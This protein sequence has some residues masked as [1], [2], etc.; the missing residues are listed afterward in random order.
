MKKNEIGQIEI[1]DTCLTLIPSGKASID[2]CLQTYPEHADFLEPLLQT[3]LQAHSH[4]SPDGPDDAYVTSTKIRIMNQ[5]QALNQGRQNV[6]DKSYRR[7]IAFPRPSLAFLSLTLVLIM[8]LSGIGVTSASAYALPGDALFPVKRGVEELRLLLTL[9]PTEEAELLLEF[10]GER[11][12]EIEDLLK[13]DPSQDLDFALQEYE[14][15]LSR[16]LE[17]TQEEEVLEDSDTLDIINSGISNH[18][19]VLQRVLEKAPASAHKGL[20]NAIQKSSHGKEVIQSIQ[21]GGNPSDLAP[22]QQKKETEDQGIP[23]DES[24]GP[25]PKDKTKGPKPKDETPEP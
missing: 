4:L 13:V 18:E 12:Q 17:M 14:G 6:K 1:L 8:L 23:A 20:E 25:K 24:H 16:L 15:M 22:G 10:A 3:A 9:R 21:E 11:L 7:R 19:E 5:I 2:D